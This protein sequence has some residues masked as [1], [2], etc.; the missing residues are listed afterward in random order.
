MDTGMIFNGLQYKWSVQTEPGQ[1]AALDREID[2]SYRIELNLKIR[3]PRP[4]TTLEDL[5]VVNERL[6]Q[7]LPELPLLLETAKV[8]PDFAKLYELK[9]DW[10][11]ERLERID[12]ILSRH[13]YY[14][15]DTILQLQHPTT[16]RRALLLQGDMDVNVDGS[17]GDRNIEVDGSGQFFQ[18]QTS[19]R[20]PKTTDRPNPFIARAQ[21]RIDQANKE[22]TKPD[23][24][25]SRRA[26]L[27]EQIDAAKRMVA[28]LKSASF[29]V[30]K[31]DPT[32]VLPGF[33]MRG[34]G[35]D[36]PKVGDYAVVIHEG[37]MYPTILG[38]AG[39]SYKMGEASLRLCNQIKHTGNPL[40]RPVSDLTVT[41]LVFPGSADPQRSAPD[42]DR[43]HAR[44]AE[45]L[46]EIGAPNAP[47][48]R[49]ENN[50]PP[51]PTPTPSP[52]PSPSPT[53]GT[54]VVDTGAPAESGAPATS[55]P[56]LSPT[57]QPG[58]SPTP[59]PTASPG[60]ALQGG[61]AG[62]P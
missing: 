7:L 56:T 39:P 21:Q 51:W 24:T 8:S 6:P 46:T 16:G 32:I 9:L 42:L 18:P 37:Q 60:P 1:T 13:N 61:P 3:E 29:L 33:M 20:W 14:D 53:S 26:E 50:V 25:E 34:S 59:S 15:C 43:W 57:P 44:C 17:D 58:V 27:R 38:D 22:L 30:S 23:L 40:A 55:A 36:V 49:W 45:L 2:S 48:H 12:Q 47:L 10:L 11:K 28:D 62:A 31:T 19:Y 35:P 4:A 41:Y 52:T 54:P 5:A